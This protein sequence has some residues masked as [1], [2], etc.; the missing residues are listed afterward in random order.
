[1]SYPAGS[2]PFWQDPVKI[3]RIRPDQWQDP[4]ISSRFGKIQPDQ[5]PDPA[6]S[7]PFWPDPARAGRIPAIFPPESGGLI[8]A[9]GTGCCQ[10]PVPIGF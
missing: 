1:M 8:P 3:F 6:E 4:I 9:P 10:T 5:W 2:R 7:L